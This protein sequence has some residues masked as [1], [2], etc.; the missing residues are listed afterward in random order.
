MLPV[1]RKVSAVIRLDG[2]DAAEMAAAVDLVE[3]P[4]TTLHIVT[5]FRID[6]DGM[7]MIAGT[8]LKGYHPLKQIITSQLP[9]ALHVGITDTTLIGVDQIETAIA[10]ATA[11]KMCSH[12]VSLLCFIVELIETDSE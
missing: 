11:I 7:Q 6:P 2:V 4:G 12:S 10:A 3:Q 9:P 1:L 5:R 8:E